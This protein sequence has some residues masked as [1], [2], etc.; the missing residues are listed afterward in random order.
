MSHGSVIF[1]LCP[2]DWKHLLFSLVEEARQAHQAPSRSQAHLQPRHQHERCA[3]PRSLWVA[4]LQDGPAGCRQRNAPAPQAP[5]R[6][7]SPSQ[8]GPSSQGEKSKAV[9]IQFKADVET[10]QRLTVTHHF[11][12]LSSAAPHPLPSEPQWPSSLP[13]R[14]RN[15]LPTGSDCPSRL[16]ST[17]PR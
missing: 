15:P 7:A 13:P 6:P 9:L 4:L 16:R 2:P 12:L 1:T 10:A 17:G 14:P 5:P 8:G 11:P 3:L